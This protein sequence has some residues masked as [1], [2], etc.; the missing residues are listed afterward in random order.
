MWSARWPSI[1][2]RQRILPVATLSAITSAKLGRE[3]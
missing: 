3:T 2:V 1:F